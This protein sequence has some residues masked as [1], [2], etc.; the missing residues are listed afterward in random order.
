[1][2]NR[3]WLVYLLA[4]AGSAFAQTPTVDKAQVNFTYQYNTD[5]AL[6]TNILSDKVTAKLT[7][8][9]KIMSVSYSSVPDGW[10]LVLPS[11]SAAGVSP[12]VLTVKANP[13]SLSP[14]TY[15]G[16]ITISNGASPVSVTVKLVITNPPSTLAL[17][18]GTGTTLTQ[19]G[20]TAYSMTLN[21]TSGGQLPTA[22]VDV[23]STGDIIPFNVATAVTKVGTTSTNW[24]LVNNIS[25]PGG[26]ASASTSGVAAASSIVQIAVTLNQS[27]LDLLDAAQYTGTITIS[28]VS[29]GSASSK[30]TSFTVTVKLSVSPGAPVLCVAGNELKY[31]SSCGS[32]KI[33]FFPQSTPVVPT[34]VTVTPIA[35]M[36]TIYGDNFFLNGSW[37]FAVRP[38]STYVALTTVW[39]SRKILTATIPISRLTP[40]QVA[41]SGEVWDILVINAAPGT[42]P[43]NAN[44]K[45]DTAKFRVTDPSQPSIQSIVNAASYLQSATQL[46]TIPNPAPSAVAPREIVSIFGQNLGPTTICPN[47]PIKFVDS[48]GYNQTKY[49]TT[50]NNTLIVGCNTVGVTF[51]VAGD[52][53]WPA[54]LIMV[55]SNQIN[56]IV[57]VEIARNDDG[58]LVIVTV[59]VAGAPT[60]ATYNA[61]K[62]GYDP[63][64]FTFGGN[65]QGQGAVLNVDPI[66]GTVTVNGAVAAPRGSPIEI[67]MTG[68][69]D[70]NP[71][72]SLADGQVAC[73]AC[74]TQSPPLF[75]LAEDSYRVLIGGQSAPIFY[76]GT[77]GT[78]VAGLVQINAIVPPSAATGTQTLT[79]EIGPILQTESNPSGITARRSQSNVTINVG[80]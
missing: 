16:S 1:M 36:L 8:T 61:Y 2:K 55:S 62:V 10:L 58:A 21:Y 51:Q 73:S 43:K 53:A 14:G 34:T 48:N 56:A 23:S 69:G 67:F 6:S 19:T 65:G 44:A 25:T 27:A 40:P 78:G 80:K 3:I 54:P 72:N 13:T 59:Y 77:A 12:L 32:V 30:G 57:P 70:Y 22:E 68:L 28:P 76:A 64:I 52:Q 38:D 20:P 66:T 50:I 37:V 4:Y 42:D 79:V 17:A 60:P 33:P 63:G 29:T 75:V 39:V 35:P 5:L 74:Y 71:S 18:A 46:G 31:P 49:D 15:F 7:T 45:S 24:L 47:T 26:L 11:G 9:T 41:P